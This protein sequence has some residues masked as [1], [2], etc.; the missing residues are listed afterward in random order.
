MEREKSQ[1]GKAGK[2]TRLSPVGYIPCTGEGGNGIERRE[3]R[4]KW[5]VTNKDIVSN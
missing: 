3:G 1:K 4:E 2:L 5:R